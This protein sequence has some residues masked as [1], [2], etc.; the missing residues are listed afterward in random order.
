MSKFIEKYRNPE[1]SKYRIP[2]LNEGE[3]ESL[4]RLITANEIEAVIKKFLA[5]K[6]PRPDGFTGEFYKTFKEEPTLSFSDYSKNSKKKELPNS[7]YEASIILIPKPDKDT[8]KKENYRPISL[9]NID[10]KILNKILAHRIQ[11]YIK[12]I[13][14]HDQVRFITGMQG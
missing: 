10:A 14:H 3:A 11:Q 6:S 13:I 2:K 1:N 5:R 7:F 9:M 8:T 4:N 12:K